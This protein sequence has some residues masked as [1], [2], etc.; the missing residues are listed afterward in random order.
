MKGDWGTHIHWGRPVPVSV[1]D[2][3][4]K[5]QLLLMESVLCQSTKLV[6]EEVVVCVIFSGGSKVD[7]QVP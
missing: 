5:D 3:L 2:A 6:N 4:G 7:V 1:R